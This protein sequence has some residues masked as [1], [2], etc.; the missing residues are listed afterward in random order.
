MVKKECGIR[1][2]AVPDRKIQ[3]PLRTGQSQ[4]DDGD[5]KVKGGEQRAE[6]SPPN[7]DRQNRKIEDKECKSRGPG[8]PMTQGDENWTPHDNPLL[9]RNKF[10][11]LTDEDIL[12]EPPVGP[13]DVEF[14]LCSISV[15]EVDRVPLTRSPA[16]EVIREVI[17]VR[18]S[19]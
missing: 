18:G 11:V 16:R 3:S 13:T 6:S 4:T 12:R 7:A 19:H 10:C 8:N 5:R 1:V 14:N 17:R 2:V 15:L 9:L